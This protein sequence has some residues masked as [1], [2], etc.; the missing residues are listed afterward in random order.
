MQTHAIIMA[1]GEGKRMQSTTPK[2]L[3]NVCGEPMIVRILKKVMQL[4][5]EKIYIVCGSTLGQIQDIVRKYFDEADNILFVNQPIARGTGDAVKQCI[6]MLENINVNVLILNGDTPL[7]DD[8]LNMFVKSATPALMVTHLDNPHGNGRIVTSSQGRFMRIVE[9][10]DATPN[11]KEIKLVNCGVYLV[12]STDLC[13]FIPLLT[14]DNAQNE[15]YLTDVCGFL[16]DRMHLVQVPKDIQYELINVNSPIDLAT[17]ERH[18]IVRNLRRI[19]MIVRPLHVTD[20]TKGYLALLCELSDTI[21]C[22]SQE[23]FDSM[24]NTINNN[25]NHHVFVIEDTIEKRVVATVTLLVEPKFIHN[26]MCVGHIEDVV[27]S[28]THRTQKLGKMLMEY[29]N[30]WMREL[31]CY[32]LILDCHEGLEAFYKMTGYTKKNIQMAIYA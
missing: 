25:N 11:E 13:A 12:S 32:K 17:A 2:V 16:K 20:F 10:K 7:I 6:P 3:H 22:K 9:E 30:T 28:R 21:T 31:N 24:V 29:V 26:G 4:N 23:F 8:T 14:C 15:Y 5:V 27:V 19:N 1:G 18:L